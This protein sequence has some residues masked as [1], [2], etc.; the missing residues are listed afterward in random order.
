[1]IS[2]ITKTAVSASLLG[3]G[4]ALGQANIFLGSNRNTVSDQGQS[5]WISTSYGPNYDIDLTLASHPGLKR[6]YLPM[7]QLQPCLAKRELAVPTEYLTKEKAVYLKCHKVG[8]EVF[9]IFS[10][11]KV[12]ERLSQTIP[13]SWLERNIEEAFETARSMRFLNLYQEIVVRHIET[14]LEE[15]FSAGEFDGV[16]LDLTYPASLLY[17]YS[18]KTREDLTERLGIDPVDFNFS[19][20]MSD[21]EKVRDRLSIEKIIEDRLNKFHSVIKR[22]SAICTTFKKPFGVFGSLQVYERPA[23]TLGAMMGDW[24]QVL[25]TYPEAFAVLSPFNNEPFDAE[26]LSALYARTKKLGIAAKIQVLLDEASPQIDILTTFNA[27]SQSQVEN[28]RTK[29]SLV[30]LSRKKA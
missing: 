8:I 14:T 25:V 6:I 9:G 5:L 16:V 26:T 22:L 30:I 20:S 15:C 13:F 17:S 12:E 18:Q 3:I 27:D 10:P 28:R 21:K 4:F 24:G 1:M 29:L 7:Y 23:T 19:L 2:P 11:L